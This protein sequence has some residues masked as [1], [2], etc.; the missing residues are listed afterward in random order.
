M[1]KFSLIIVLL[2]TV[3]YAIV[4]GAIALFYTIGPIPF[5]ILLFLL[6]VGESNVNNK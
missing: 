2:L 3:F 6:S 4:H 1:F 5:I